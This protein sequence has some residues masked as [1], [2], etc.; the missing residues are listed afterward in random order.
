MVYTIGMIELFERHS[1][2]YL[3]QTVLDALQQYNIDISRVYSITTD[4]GANVIKTSKFLQEYCENG[5]NDNENLDV[6]IFPSFNTTISQSLS[7]VHCA[8]HTLQLASWDAIK[9]VNEPFSLLR[10]SAKAIR[11]KHEGVANKSYSNNTKWSNH[12]SF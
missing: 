3:K 1:A 2:L 4:N 5:I 12:F 9:K 8:A 11:K 6:D 10:E 7:V